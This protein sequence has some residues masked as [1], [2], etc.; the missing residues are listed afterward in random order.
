MLFFAAL[1]P[2]FALTGDDT[3]AN[4]RRTGCLLPPTCLALGTVS[5]AEFEDSGEVRLASPCFRCFL[6]CSVVVVVVVVVVVLLAVIP[7]QHRQFF[8]NVTKFASSLPARI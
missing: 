3:P 1:F 7:K 4:S 6:V 5:F 2:Y 8:G